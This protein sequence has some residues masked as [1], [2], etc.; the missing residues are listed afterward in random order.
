MSAAT[1]PT[2]KRIHAIWVAAPAIPDIPRRPATIAMIRKV[3]AQFSMIAPQIKCQF[4]TT[5]LF[6]SP[7]DYNHYP[8]PR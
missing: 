5:R 3:T 4:T 8:D 1:S 6:D 2:T 7:G